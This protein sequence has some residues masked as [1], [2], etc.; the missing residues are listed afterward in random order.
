[1]KV[2][3]IPAYIFEKKINAIPYL[4][5]YFNDLLKQQEYWY[6]SILQYLKYPLLPPP[7]KTT[8][9]DVINNA[10]NEDNDNNISHNHHPK[11]SNKS[12]HC[13]LEKQEQEKISSTN[14]NGDNNCDFLTKYELTLQ[15]RVKKNPKLNRHKLIKE[16]QRLLLGEDEDNE[17]IEYEEPID[18]YSRFDYIDD[19]DNENNSAFH[20]QDSINYLFLKQYSTII[21]ND[22]IIDDKTAKDDYYEFVAPFPSIVYNRQYHGKT[23][24]MIKTSN[25]FLDPFHAYYKYNSVQNKPQ[26]VLKK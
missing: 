15:D 3:A 13:P 18:P 21:D 5:N 20:Y 10:M 22:F 19:N 23:L 11:S 1:M 4:S 14:N 26:N 8:A 2:L 9:A 25:G 16:F 6:S 7:S 17:W 24:P 12:D